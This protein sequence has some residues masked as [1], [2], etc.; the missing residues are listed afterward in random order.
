[1]R[2]AQAQAKQA[3]QATN[4]NRIEWIKLTDE[5]ETYSLAFHMQAGFTITEKWHKFFYHIDEVKQRIREF[6]TGQSRWQA[7]YET[8]IDYN[9]NQTNGGGEA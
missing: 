6:Y 3:K 1:M 7:D 4:T 8:L 2:Q 9:I 5:G